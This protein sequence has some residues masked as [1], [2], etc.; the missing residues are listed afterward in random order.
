MMSLNIPFL[1]CLILY[2]LF[3]ILFGR[4]TYILLNTECVGFSDIEENE[5]D[6]LFSDKT[7]MRDM[8]IIYGVFWIIFLPIT[9]F[10]SFKEAK[11]E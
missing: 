4:I 7:L 10:N 2:T 6:E 5:K 8:S 11:D 1:V 3:G 9:I